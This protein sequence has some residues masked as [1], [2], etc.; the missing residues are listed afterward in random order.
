MFLQSGEPTELEI[1]DSIQAFPNK[2]VLVVLRSGSGEKLRWSLDMLGS[3][4]IQIPNIHDRT[5]FGLLCLMMTKIGKESLGISEIR[6]NGK[7]DDPKYFFC[8]DIIP[9]R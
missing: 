8:A 9:A 4:E 2:G 5:D 3:H 7:P 1:G 6:Q